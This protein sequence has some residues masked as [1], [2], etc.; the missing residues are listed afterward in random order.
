MKHIQFMEGKFRKSVRTIMTGYDLLSSGAHQRAKG[1]SRHK[2]FEVIAANLGSR[3]RQ[4][5]YMTILECGMVS[6]V[7]GNISLH[8]NS[9]THFDDVPHSN[10]VTGGLCEARRTEWLQDRERGCQ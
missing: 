8:L 4:A 6:T 5:G 2:C 3:H 1:E 10:Y 9:N 7:D